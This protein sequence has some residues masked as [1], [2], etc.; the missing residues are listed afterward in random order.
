MG[1]YGASSL[2]CSWD[3]KKVPQV[4]CVISRLGATFLLLNSASWIKGSQVCLF[5]LKRRGSNLMYHWKWISCY[6]G[7]WVDVL[8]GWWLGWWAKIRNQKHLFDGFETILQ[9]MEQFSYFVF[10]RFPMHVFSIENDMYTPLTSVG[11][12]SPEVNLPASIG[13]HL[14]AGLCWFCFVLFFRDF[15]FFFW[16]SSPSR[17]WMVSTMDAAMGC[18][19]CL[20][21]LKCIG[22]KPCCDS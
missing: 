15:F 7:S 11:R 18:K 14:M 17:D 12:G 22:S 1:K 16:W 10:T 8:F 3:V 13:M 21:D 6:I 4:S 5:I 2:L 9:L 20:W 19:R